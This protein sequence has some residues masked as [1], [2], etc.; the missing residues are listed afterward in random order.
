M[1]AKA[2]RCWE[3][4]L[5][6]QK[7]NE[8]DMMRHSTRPKAYCSC[9]QRAATEENEGTRITAITRDM[10]PGKRERLNMGNVGFVEWD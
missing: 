5:N 1:T 4:P 9:D 8:M 3:F 7:P 6:K 2:Y 10:G